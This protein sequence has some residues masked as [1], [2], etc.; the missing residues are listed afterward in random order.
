MV[1]VYKNTHGYYAINQDPSPR[2]DNSMTRGHQFKLQKRSSRTASAGTVYQY[3]GT[4][5][6]L[7]TV[8]YHFDE[9]G[10][11]DQFCLYILGNGHL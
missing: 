4:V 7:L 9:F 11:S 3:T 5:S 6:I 8:I 10:T 2:E 1:E